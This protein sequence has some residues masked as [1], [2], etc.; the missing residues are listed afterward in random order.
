[1]RRRWAKNPTYFADVRKET[2]GWRDLRP[3]ATPLHPNQA[4]P[5]TKGETMEGGQARKERASCHLVP[6]NPRKIAQFRLIVCLIPTGV[7]IVFLIFQI[8]KISRI[9]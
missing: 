3:L 7:A 1:M 4:R 8:S 2:A 6:A 5:I 9:W